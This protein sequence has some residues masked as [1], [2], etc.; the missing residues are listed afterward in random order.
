MNIHR[1][2]YEF[3]KLVAVMGWPILILI[4][5]LFKIIFG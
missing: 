3:S 4:M 5:A 1:V 2:N